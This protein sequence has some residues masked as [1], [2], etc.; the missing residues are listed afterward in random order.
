[1]RKTYLAILL[2][3]MMCITLFAGGQK[4]DQKPA[5]NELI[6]YSFHSIERI[7]PLY[8]EFQDR[9]GIRIHIINDSIEVLVPQLISELD[10]PIADILWGG[11]PETFQDIQNLL[12]PYAHAHLDK[13]LPSTKNPENWW[14]GITYTPTVIVYNQRLITQEDS[15]TGWGDLL[16]PKF[17][18]RIAYADPT[19]SGPAFKIF[20]T[21]LLAMG[22]DSELGWRYLYDFV[23]NLEG[24]VIDS[25][26]DLYKKIADGEYVVGVTNEVFTSEFQGLGPNVRVVY[27]VEGSSRVPVPIAIINGAKNL[28]NARAFVDFLLS[29]DVQGILGDMDLNT[30]RIDIKPLENK[31]PNDQGVDIPYDYDWVRISKNRLLARWKELLIDW[32]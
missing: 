9:T 20:I 15:P 29:E 14:H 21:Q 26:L 18:G 23:D 1:M 12:Q 22:G 25:N 5:K 24:K 31:F 13:V 28:D 2:L 4:K 17:R 10:N 30:V 32:R 6:I 19:K 8:R 7:K 16:N 11:N 27:P 3:L